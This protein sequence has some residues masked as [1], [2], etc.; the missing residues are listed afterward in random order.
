MEE[1]VPGAEEGDAKE[2]T[3]VEEEEQVDTEEGKRGTIQ[4]A[5][6]CYIKNRTE[7]CHT[8]VLPLLTLHV[9]FF[10]SCSLFFSYTSVLILNTC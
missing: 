6:S 8:F 10:L 7:V 3:L 1:A 4:Q 2:A 9:L 5:T